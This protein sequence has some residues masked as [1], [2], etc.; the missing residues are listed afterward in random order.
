MSI[1][2]ARRCN[3]HQS[4][5]GLNTCPLLTVIISAPLCHC[6]PVCDHKGVVCGVRECVSV[7]N[8]YDVTK[9]VTDSFSYIYICKHLHNPETHL[10]YTGQ[11]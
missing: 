1:N 4:Q 9:S 5:G 6:R 10:D 2:I 8:V 11:F 3:G 7:C